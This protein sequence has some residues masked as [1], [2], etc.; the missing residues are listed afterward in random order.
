MFCAICIRTSK[1]L[2]IH[3]S[4]DTENS[5]KWTDSSIGSSVAANRSLYNLSEKN[6]AIGE[7]IFAMLTKQV[8]SVWYAEILSWA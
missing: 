2:S 7:D 3:R 8:N 5:D 4:S 1:S 6:G